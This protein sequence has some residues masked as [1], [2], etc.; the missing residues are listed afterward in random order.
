MNEIP[1]LKGRPEP[2]ALKARREWFE[3]QALA[4][5][6]TLEAVART[7]TGLVT[8]LL[9][10]LFGVLTVAEDPL[11]AYL[12]IPLTRP[13][14][15]TAVVALLIALACALAVLLPHR[16]V[17]SPHRLDEQARAFQALL[18]RKSRWLTAGVIAFGLALLAL[19][20]I[21][22]VAIARAA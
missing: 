6:D 10:V 4:A 14:G 21:L 20:A 8:A 11:P 2:P 13:L 1:T 15:I 17:V 7:L 12:W 22:I 16:L 18:T 3:R 19:G 9:S 5:P